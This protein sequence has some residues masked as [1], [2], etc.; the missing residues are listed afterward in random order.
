MF[1]AFKAMYSSLCRIVFVIDTPYIIQRKGTARSAEETP[2]LGNKH[3]TCLL[4][5][6]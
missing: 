1:E 4:V 2:Y 3:K 6:V 5:G